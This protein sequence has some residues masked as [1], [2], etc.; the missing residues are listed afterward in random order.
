M[1]LYQLEST[2]V[3]N[4]AGFAEQTLES[5]QPF[6]NSL[7]AQLAYPTRDNRNRISLTF[8]AFIDKS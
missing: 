2:R 8:A 5:L 7:P 1:M 3:R 4:S 6:R